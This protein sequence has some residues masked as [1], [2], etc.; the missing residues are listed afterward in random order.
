MV[1]FLETGNKILVCTGML[2]IGLYKFINLYLYGEI[3]NR[4]EIYTK[5]NYQQEG[6][7]L[8]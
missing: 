7:S 5:R 2:K 6:K 1:L 8:I 4:N 3:I